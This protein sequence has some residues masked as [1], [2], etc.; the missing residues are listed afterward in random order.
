MGAL[1]EYWERGTNYSDEA[2]RK[3]DA[4][5]V[6]LPDNK[7]ES[8]IEALPRGTCSE[9]RL[10]MSLNRRIWLGYTLSHSK[11]PYIYQTVSSNNA[12]LGKGGTTDIVQVVINE[13]N[14]KDNHITEYYNDKR[15]EP[16]HTINDKFER[17][18]HAY[19][20]GRISRKTYLDFMWNN[21]NLGHITPDKYNEL[22]EIVNEFPGVRTFLSAPNPKYVER[23]DI[24]G[25]AFED[26]MGRTLMWSAGEVSQAEPLVVEYINVLD[27]LKLTQY[28]INKYMCG[29]D[30]SKPDNRLL[31][32]LL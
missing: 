22:I 31:I 3:A 16:T 8:G 17:T 32:M 15:G 25:K 23:T 13:H 26:A 14:A 6:I 4:V 28:K 30:L 19:K 29:I 24:T 18:I 27:Q 21:L 2:L 7:W 11:K 9:I 12:I 1:V 5:V 10:A 20:N